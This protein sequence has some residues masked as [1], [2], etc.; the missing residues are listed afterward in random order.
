MQD[1]QKEIAFFNKHAVSQEFDVFSEAS[2]HKLI[3]T[4]VQL[5]GWQLGAKVADLGCGSGVF[6]SLLQKKGFG[7]FGIDLSKSIMA[8][9]RS[10][11]AVEFVTGDVENLAL[12]SESLDGV[13]LSGILH[14]LPDLSACANEIFRVLNEAEGN[15]CGL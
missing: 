13:L 12:R 11:F 2:N 4:C 8:V 15:I 10:R 3:E 14:H 5:S 1:K 9:G 7:S 6:T